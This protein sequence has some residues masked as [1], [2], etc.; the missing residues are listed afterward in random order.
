MIE[1]TDP[2]VTEK[3]LARCAECDRE[4]QHYNVFLSPLNERNVICWECM[5]SNDKGYN[6]DRDFF[7]R[8]RQGVI[9]PR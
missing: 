9:K 1:S 5:Q 7:R 3:P 2:K 8:S 4:V 6:A